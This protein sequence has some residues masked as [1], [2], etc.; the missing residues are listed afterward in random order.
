[1]DYEEELEQEREIA[2]M[3]DALRVA[4]ENL[5]IAAKDSDT[6]D[7]TEQ[8]EPS[9]PTVESDN[10]TGPQDPLPPTAESSSTI[11]TK[12]DLPTQVKKIYGDGRCLFRS[13]VV[14]CDMV[15]LSCTRNE[16]GWPKDADLA[17]RETEFADKLRK[18]TVD[19]WRA[20]KSIYE[21]HVHDLGLDHFWM[22][23]GYGNIDKRIS[24][25]AKPKTFAG[26]AELLAL[27]H[28][29]KRPIAVHY[30]NAPHRSLQLGEVYTGSANTV[31]LL[32]YQMIRTIL[33]IM[34]F[35]YMAIVM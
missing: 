22:D 21:S 32:N 16:G 30:Q 5:T 23:D 3:V 7:I 34:T 25:M 28:I 24:E 29:I 27:V 31:H 9:A 8:Q 17:K 35:W 4:Q 20:N 13:V 2:E 6:S 14:A 26:E 11:Q 18:K 15:L 19:L 1:M 12:S 10:V 33:D